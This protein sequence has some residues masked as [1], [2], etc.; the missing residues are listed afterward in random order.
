MSNMSSKMSNKNRRK[1]VYSGGHLWMQYY[2]SSIAIGILYDSQNSLRCSELHL[3]RPL[4]A[5]S[6]GSSPG[7]ATIQFRHKLTTHG[8]GGWDS[9]GAGAALSLNAEVRSTPQTKAL[10]LFP[11]SWRSIMELHQD[12]PARVRPH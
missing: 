2:K 10:Q 7:N 11:A 3:C 12:C 4:K 5:E 8:T 6:P 1:R 9:P